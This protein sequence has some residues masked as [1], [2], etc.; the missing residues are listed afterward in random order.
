M[1]K[2]IAENILTQYLNIQY[3]KI[4]IKKA[5]LIKYKKGTL[6]DKA[7]RVKAPDLYQELSEDMRIVNGFLFKTLTRDTLNLMGIKLSKSNDAWYFRG[8]KR[9]SPP[10]NLQ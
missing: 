1:L 9:V 7:N 6:K 3:L 4:E 2:S 5:F 10:D 8:A